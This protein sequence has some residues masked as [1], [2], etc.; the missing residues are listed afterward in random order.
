MS[1]DSIFGKQNKKNTQYESIFGRSLYTAPAEDPLDKYIREKKLGGTI[2]QG[3]PSFFKTPDFSGEDITA[4]KLELQGK[5]GI[6]GRVAEKVFNVPAEAFTNVVNKVSDLF[7]VE[8]VREGSVVQ[9][10]TMD[11]P[12]KRL[13]G[14][15]NVASS[16][17]GLIPQWLLLQ[18]ELEAAKEVPVLKYPAKAVSYG[19]E[20]LGELGSFLGEKGLDITPISDESKEILREPVISLATI[21][22]QVGTL[23]VAPKGIKAG[24]EKLPISKEAKGKITQIAAPAIAIGFKPLSTPLK[25]LYSGIRNGIITRQ[26]GISDNGIKPLFRGTTL[27]EWDN[28][29]QGGFSGEQIGFGKGKV[30]RTWLAEDVETAQG[31]LKMRGGKGEVIIEIKPEARSK[32]Y[33]DPNSGYYRGDN[34]GINDIA[35]V[36]DKNGK[37]IYE[38]PNLGKQKANVEITTDIAKEIVNEVVKNVPVKS[39][40]ILKIPFK[41]RVIDIHTDN[42]LVLENLIK[43]KEDID[44]RVVKTLGRDLNGKTIAAKYVFDYKTKRSTIYTTDKTTGGNLAHEL[45]HYLDQKISSDI[46]NKLSD[47]IPDYNKYKLPIESSIIKYAIDSLEGNATAKEISAKIKLLTETFNKDVEKLSPGE[48][49]ERYADKFATAVKEVV[50]NSKQAIKIAPN[51]SEFINYYLAKEGFITERIR[52][53]MGE[54]RKPV[55]EVPVEKQVKKSEIDQE[56][57]TK[58]MEYDN[59]KDFY[60]LSGGK[61]N[62]ELRDRG[63]RGQEQVSKFWEEL[64]GKT[65]IDDYKMSHRPSKSG[66]ASNIPQESLPNFYERPEIYKHG[67]KEYQESID[68]LQRIKGKPNSTIT[69]YRAGPKNELRTGD[70]VTFSKEKARRESLTENVP[71]QEFKVKVK[72]VQFAGDDITEFGYWGEPVKPKPK[73]ETKPKVEPTTKG[74]RSVDELIERGYTKKEA[75]LIIRNRTEMLDIKSPKDIEKTLDQYNRLTGENK[76]KIYRV[77]EKGI[78]LKEGKFV[79]TKKQDAVDFRENLGFKRGQPEITET[80]VKKSDLLKPKAE[81]FEGE[82]IYYPEKIKPIKPKGKPSGVAL[83]VEAKAIEKGLTKKFKDLA[84]FTPTTIKKQAKK[85]KSAEEFVK[86]Q[87]KVFRGTSEVSSDIKGKAIYTTP[88]KELAKTYGGVKDSYI[89]GGK[90]ADLTNTKL[91]EE[92]IGKDNFNQGEKLFKSFNPERQQKILKDGLSALKR[93]ELS[94]IQEN[95]LDDYL[96]VKN[97]DFAKIDARQVKLQDFLKNKGFDYYKNE[98]YPGIFGKGASTRGEEIIV[99]N[100]DILKTK[101]QLTDIYTQATKGVEKKIVK[102]KAEPTKLPALK[103]KKFIK[104]ESKVNELQNQVGELSSVLS[105]DP[106]KQLSKYTNKQGLLPEVTGEKTSKFAQKG[107]D[108]VTELGFK[109]SEQARLAYEKYSQSRKQLQALKIKLSETKKDTFEDYNQD[110]IDRINSIFQTANE[111]VVETKKR[112]GLFS[113]TGLKTGEFVKGRKSFNPDKINAPDDVDTLLTGIAEKQGEFK[114]QRI[115]K[116]DENLKQLANEVGVTVEDLLK[117]EPGS[118]ANAETVLKSRQI[119]AE[120]AQDLRDTIRQTT[121]ETASGKELALIKEKLFRLQ[122][123]MK[124][125]AGLRTEASNVFRQF[126]MEAIAGENDIIRDLTSR[127]KKIEG[128]TGGDL[129][130]FL[131]K[132]KKLIEPTYADKAWHLW[133]MSILSGGSTQIKNNFGNLSQGLGEIATLTARNPKEF[134]TAMVGLMEGLRTGKK[135]AVEIWKEGE[136]SKYEE[137]GRKPIIFTGKA[138]WL[139]LFDYVGR[140]MAA[141]DALAR[142]GFRGMEAY[143]KAREIAVNE[144]LRGEEVRRR[145]L[146]LKDE[147]KSD[148]EVQYFSSRGTYTQKPEGIIGLFSE[149]LGRLANKVPGGK[150]ILP[151][152]RIVANVVNNSLDWTPLGLKRG[153]IKP[154]KIKGKTYF[155]EGGLFYK[156]YHSELTAR[157]RGK[158]LTRGALGTMAM[159]YFAT[160]AADE[161]LSGNGPLNYKKKQQLKDSGWRENSIKIG[162]TWYP[163]Q[164]W[165]PMAIPMTIV[166]N[167]F[168]SSKYT[169]IKDEDLFNRVTLS[170]VGSAS[171]ILDMSFL[172]GPSELVNLIS[173]PEMNKN[174][175]KRFVAQQATSPI[176]NLFKQTA[177][178]FDPTIYTTNTIK[179][180]IL[181][182]LRLTSGLKPK[183]N[184]FGQPIK[185]EALTELQP[186]KET[187]DETIKFLAKNELWI[188]VPSKA[189]KIKPRGDKESRV[190]TEDEYYKY[191]EYSG[192]EI[193]EKIDDNLGRLKGYSQEKRIDKIREWVSDIRSDVKRDIERGKI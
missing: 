2:S 158:S 9:K 100:K 24:F 173:D 46:N 170:L 117:V 141:G 77:D 110:Q 69:I 116:T 193:K 64:T 22:T 160:L 157:Q 61:I 43:G 144:G 150:L 132:A 70:W 192:K 127:L 82:F 38:A 183:L 178:Y 39:E 57:F 60:E 91:L 181:S 12:V 114:K 165:G 50:T 44:Y 78:V 34:I 55:E 1:Y 67:G 122:G 118:I 42:K 10:S 125:V 86:A 53:T 66:V 58:A 21:A 124:T 96:F 176:P 142:E 79:F 163:Y 16:L 168:D 93:D 174:Y 76:I 102:P 190:M 28:I 88:N 63:I 155:Q 189:T 186:V 148:P 87:P 73:T 131:T 32:T 185:G 65:S 167:Y 120:M 99:L 137:Y 6:L 83:S 129:T 13:A 89:I 98:T 115:S 81:G 159:I 175:L 111:V 143:G 80:T 31:A 56:I 48:T 20:K 90:E 85:Y 103:Q 41:D 109:D 23:K 180:K 156:Y 107:D 106:I 154:V 133:Y 172:R 5:G 139:N 112:T 184:V 135:R 153:F 3:A 94:K 54:A 140:L 7:E 52:E 105:G 166:G 134:P 147:L 11:T 71:I 74:A 152:T 59:G 17:I 187:K 179:E 128:E 171:S 62:Q 84:E 136:T 27:L 92:F 25:L 121:T 19:F 119:V 30:N 164:N 169:N 72:E 97:P 8:P 40:G 161:K 14:G 108:L 123:V 26:K 29:K 47:L 162:N 138:K 191:I 36:T 149:N 35:R 75:E 95:L 45:G 37:I 68:V 113:G 4:P 15:L 182:N 104:N 51:F 18:T 33:K 130:S 146:E 188:T 145:V 177:R 151:F 101:S 126:K 49:R